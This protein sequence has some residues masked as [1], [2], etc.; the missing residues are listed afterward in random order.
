MSCALLL[1]VHIPH[2][3]KVPCAL[4]P[5][6]HE[7]G[8]DRLLQALVAKAGEKPRSP[9]LALGADGQQG[10]QANAWTC[11]TGRRARGRALGVT[12]QSAKAFAS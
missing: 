5:C 9:A 3:E 11:M 8:L 4:V 7:S 6:K 10:F 2:P 12:R 1:P